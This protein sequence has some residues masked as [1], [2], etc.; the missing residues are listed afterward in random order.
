MKVLYVDDNTDHTDCFLKQTSKMDI[1]VRTTD[2]VFDIPIQNKD[3]EPDL[4]VLDFYLDASAS[5]AFDYLKK[6]NV[7]TVVVTAADISSVKSEVKKFE[8]KKHNDIEIL[9]K[10]GG[11]TIMNYIRK[12]FPVMA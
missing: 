6:R 11:K 8:Q 5:I 7:R 10:D 2:S 4:V 12:T 1:E 3:F 9:P